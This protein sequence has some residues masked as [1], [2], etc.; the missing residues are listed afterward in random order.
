MLREH[1]ALYAAVNPSD[2]Q[3]KVG[4][5]F[6]RRDANGQLCRNDCKNGVA[7]RSDADSEAMVKI[8]VTEIDNCARVLAMFGAK[9][10]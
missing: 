9:G 1:V 5:L 2:A 8:G 4:E 10:Q 7:A 3:D 6:V